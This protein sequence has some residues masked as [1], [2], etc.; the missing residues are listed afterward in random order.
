ME[1]KDFE[2]NFIDK[3]YEYDGL[4]GRRAKCGI[5]VI[6]T[7]SEHLVIVTDLY[8]ENPGDSI[9]GFC[10]E[11]ATIISGN[12]KLDLDKLMF[13]HH[14]PEVNSSLDFYE[15]AFYKIEFEQAD[16]SI[17]KPDWHPISRTEVEILV[18]KRLSEKQT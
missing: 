12:Y 5:K 8:K 17:S 4:W 1:L 14:V 9:T 10:A 13:I 7:E 6:K 18:N 2:Y 11:L 3:I 16:N 15:E